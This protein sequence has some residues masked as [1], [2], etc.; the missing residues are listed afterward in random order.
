MKRLKGGKS[1]GVDG[2]TV[3]MLNFGGE[4]VVMWMHLICSLA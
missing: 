1:P 3:E 2:I 4:M